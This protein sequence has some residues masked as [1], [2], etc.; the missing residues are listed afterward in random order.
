MVESQAAQCISGD[1]CFCLHFSLFLVDTDFQ[2]L[3]YTT[4]LPSSFS[5]FPSSDQLRFSKLTFQS[6]DTPLLR[7]LSKARRAWDEGLHEDAVQSVR[8]QPAEDQRAVCHTL[9]PLG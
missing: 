9:G 2:N 8:L 4:I 6:T 7:R 1:G 3:V 5:R